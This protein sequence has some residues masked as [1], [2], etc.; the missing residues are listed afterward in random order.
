MADAGDPALTLR[1]CVVGVLVLLLQSAVTQVYTAKPI[2]LTLSNVFMIL[3]CWALLYAWVVFMPKAR[4]VAGTRLAWLG[5]ALRVLNPGPMGL[6]E[7]VVATALASSGMYG[8]SGANVLATLKL[9][10]DD[11]ITAPMAVF[12]LLSIG[13]LGV[14][15]V[16]LLRPIIIYPSEM[17][18]WY[19]LPMVAVFSMLHHERGKDRKRIKAFSILFGVTFLWEPIVAYIAPMLNGVSVFCIASMG[20]PMRVSGRTRMAA[21]GQREMLTRAPSMLYPRT[22]PPT[23]CPH[24]R[25]RLVQPVSTPNRTEGAA[26]TDSADF[27]GDSQRSRPP[28]PVPRPSIRVPLAIRGLPPQGE[29][30]SHRP[31]YT[32]PHP[33]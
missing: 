11:S 32:G 17:V 19:T 27:R 21:A 4:W 2:Q 24:L 8:G 23:H 9:F 14:G 6:K 3:I 20:A 33:H 1:G 28:L 31:L 16:G 22:D 30:P 10:Y 18:Y 5:P 15:L 12:G 13:V 29:W 25:R 26:C 7:H